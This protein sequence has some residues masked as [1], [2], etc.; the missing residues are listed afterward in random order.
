MSEYSYTAGEEREAI[1]AYLRKKA[2]GMVLEPVLLSI[3][4]EIEA[5]KHNAEESP[6]LKS[7]PEI[8]APLAGVRMADITASR[9]CPKCG[10]IESP[11]GTMTEHCIRCG[12]SF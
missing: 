2:S 12:H 4:A 8:T 7:R 3:A 6:L 9:R 5:G 10:S 11:D 1:V